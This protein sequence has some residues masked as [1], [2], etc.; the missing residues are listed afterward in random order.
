MSFIMIIIIYTGSHSGIS[1]ESVP[2]FRSETAC[3]QAMVQVTRTLT[4]L[5]SS[6]DRTTALTCVASG[7]G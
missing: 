4:Q 5:T 2:G 7:N 3:K 6:A 1:V